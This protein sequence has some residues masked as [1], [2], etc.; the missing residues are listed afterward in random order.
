MAE[1]GRRQL[2]RTLLARAADDLHALDVLRT[3][4]VADAVV[5]FH[6]QQAVEKSL[7]A[8]LAAHGVEYRFS[9]DLSYLN[10]LLAEN[11]IEV[12][13]ELREAETLRPWAIEL[14]YEDPARSGATL[15]RDAAYR[16]ATVTYGWAERFFS[17]DPA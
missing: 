4:D 17:A 11:G 8:V 12:P 6:A 5:G 16:H 3:A 15:D 7:K 13:P 2:G 14:R 10:D 1:E 9:H